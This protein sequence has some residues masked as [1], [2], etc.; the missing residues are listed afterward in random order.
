[1]GLVATVLNAGIY[2]IFASTIC[3]FRLLV[4][5]LP[6]SLIIY[7]VRGVSIWKISRKDDW[8]LVDK[9]TIQRRKFWFDVGIVLAGLIWGA[10]G[11]FS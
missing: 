10:D 1:L 7:A 5:G 11:V 9:K 8:A 4:R 6:F 3:H 2:F